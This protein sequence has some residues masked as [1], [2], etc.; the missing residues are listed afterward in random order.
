MDEQTPK[1]S[2]SDETFENPPRNGSDAKL[3][4]TTM[5]NALFGSGL[6][7]KSFPGGCSATIASID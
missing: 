3:T 7:A 2:G 6:A 5:T 1:F 4:L